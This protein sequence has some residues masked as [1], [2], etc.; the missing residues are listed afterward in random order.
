MMRF[1]GGS[2]PRRARFSA[3]SVFLRRQSCQLP[4]GPSKAAIVFITDRMSNRLDGLRSRRE[5]GAST[6]DTTTQNKIQ[7]R[8]T[9]KFDEA[10]EERALA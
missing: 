2:N 6:L 10:P 3:R 5:K 4:E 9:R 1:P 7:R 8:R